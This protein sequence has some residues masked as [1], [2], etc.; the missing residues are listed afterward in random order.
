MN[1]INMKC[2]EK[3][4][5]DGNILFNKKEYA[6]AISCYSEALMLPGLPTSD[7]AVLYSN[8]SAALRLSGDLEGAK[9]DAKGAVHLRPSWWRSYHRLGAAYEALNKYDTIPVLWVDLSFVMYEY[10]A[11]HFPNNLT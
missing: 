10:D 9:E 11:P 7:I 2:A 5:E 1:E 3:L 4:R 6:D 8:R